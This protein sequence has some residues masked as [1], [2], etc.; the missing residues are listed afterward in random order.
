MK[1]HLIGIGGIGV[2]ALATYYLAKGHE[3][4]GSDL[5]ET[6]IIQ[7]LR[8]KGAAIHIGAH[9]AANILSNTDRIIY[10]PAIQKSNS[11]LQQAQLIR[12]PKPRRTGWDRELDRGKGIPTLSYPQALGE[13]TKTHYTI[14]VSGTHG[15]STTT[16]MLALIL[17]K[18]GLDPTVIVGT[19]IKEFGNSNC[20]VGRDS[21]LIK[22][23][24]ILLIEADEH[25]ASFLNYS[26]DII[27]LTSIEPDHL[28]YYKNIGNILK[29]FSKYVLRLPIGGHL[30]ANKDDANVLKVVSGKYLTHYYSKNYR[31]SI[32]LRE[33]LKVPGEHNVSNAAAAL[34]CA[35][36]L[37]VPNQII[38]EALSEFL[39][40]WRRFEIIE[41]KK[42]PRSVLPSYTLVNDYGHHPTEVRVTLEAARDKWPKRQIW[43]IFQP[44]QYQRTYYF[45]HSFIR[46]LA[47][48]SINR[49]ILVPIYDVA[50]RENKTLKANISSQSIVREIKVRTDNPKAIVYIPNFAKVET[51]LQEQ[52]QGGE[53]V[54]VMGAGDIYNKLAIPLMSRGRG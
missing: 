19:K 12:R 44:H 32:R 40:T 6:E 54:I 16:A 21:Y 9:R 50:G 29:A 46:T 24:P 53:V 33:I 22:K 34:T 48:A 52:L 30:V 14:A 11:E 1:I 25:F 27:V 8:K 47:Q 31:A 28:D 35:R 36:I 7:A 15:K 13:L 4:S 2:S 45:F 26:P 20:R 5:V 37:K 41:L 3:V 23:K 39:G 10:S 38:H 51:Y 18:A 49:I 42:T 43:L 17:V